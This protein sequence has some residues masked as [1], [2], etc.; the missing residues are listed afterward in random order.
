[1]PVG[2]LLLLGTAGLLA[3][4]WP[5]RP[6][7]NV[8]VVVVD[9]LRQDHLATYG[10]ARDTA[11]FLD[12]LAR[13]GVTLDGISPSSWTKPAAASILTG[14]HPVTHQAIDR[15]DRL[16]EPAVTLAE[17][18]RREGYRTFAASANGWVSPAFGFEQGFDEFLLNE[19][20]NIRARELNRE[21]LPRLLQLQEPFF[22]YVHYIDPHVPYAPATDWRGD[23]M[24]AALAPVLPG[25][26]AD[27]DALGR[28]P[29]FRQRAIDLYDG[30]IRGADGG[31][32]ELVGALRE[33]GLA[34]RTLLVVTSDHGE[35]FEEHGRMSHGQTLYDE[36]LRVPLI[37]HGPGLYPG[38]RL[39]VASLADIV[40]TV[41]DLVGLPPGR[42]RP[43]ADGSSLAAALI[44]G[45]LGQSPSGFLGH[46]DFV[47]GVSLSYTAGEHK[48]VLAKRPY[49]KQIF[50]LA[51]DR[52]ERRNLI[53]TEVGDRLLTELGAAAAERFNE[54]SRNPLPR[55]A[56]TLQA[57]LAADLAAL[58]YLAVGAPVRPRSIPRRITVPDARPN[59]RLGWE[60]TVDASACI[61][62]VDPG[63]D[64]LLLEGWH[65]PEQGGRWTA[66]F[67]SS[68]LGL[69]TT[70]AEVHLE[71]RGINHR[72]A[73]ARLAA[74]VEGRPVLDQEI[75]VG[76]FQVK[77]RFSGVG[78]ESPVL[79][80]LETSTGYVPA[81]HGA[82]DLR[83][84][85]LF[86]TSLCLR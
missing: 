29:Q 83:T 35:E 23:S 7:L 6:A 72:P 8:V 25:D 9:T 24:P 34:D 79:L 48:M 18:L 61:E 30:E 65:Y 49:A 66:P 5:Q 1:M 57:R 20:M 27:T 28:S 84:L 16:P 32:A 37:F 11:P 81:Q 41:V 80:V 58:G 69:P 47:D 4:L 17:I 78:L 39:G 71:L 52:G 13:Q 51:T 67:A 63:A 22:L 62:L 76:P 21:L 85:G 14:L 50:H 46:L 60:P 68:L 55:L 26:L 15:Q 36:V 3:L 56:A 42:S 54:Y 2:A 70:A 74:M 12:S 45:R 38:A 73:P 86:F 82:A 31:V 44:S 75:E 53:G 10:Y 40:P 77:G 19:Q 33:R 64:R 59:G 43:R